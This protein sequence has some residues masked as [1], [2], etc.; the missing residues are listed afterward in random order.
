ME[1]KVPDGLPYLTLPHLEF[2][3]DIISVAVKET[4]LS[5]I[6]YVVDARILY[7]IGHLQLALASASQRSWLFLPLHCLLPA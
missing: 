6:K 1:S 7:I 5:H 2:T 4:T 3:F